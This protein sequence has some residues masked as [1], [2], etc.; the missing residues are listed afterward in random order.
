MNTYNDSW[1][2]EKA[3]TVSGEVNGRVANERKVCINDT[4]Y[5]LANDKTGA[6]MDHDS[7]LY[8]I[9]GTRSDLENGDDIMLVIVGDIAYYAESVSGNDANRSVA[10]VYD[11]YD[12]G[13]SWNDTHQ[14]KIILANGDKLTVDVDMDETNV[15]WAD[16]D[17][18]DNYGKLY[19]Y[20]VN[21]DDEYAFT[22]LS[23]N[24]ED[25]G[26][27]IV[28]DNNAG[29]DGSRVNTTA[30]TKYTI[31]DEAI[32][33]AYIEDKRDAEVYTGEALKD[34]NK[35]GNWGKT[36]VGQ[37]LADNQSGFTYARMLNIKIDDAD[38][39][40]NITNYGYMVEDSVRMTRDGVRVMRYTYWN[41]EE[42]VTSYEETNSNREPQI[43][44]GA[45][46][47]FSL[48]EDD[49]ITDVEY[50]NFDNT[51]TLNDINN[52][53]LELVYAAMSG[54]D[55]DGY[56]GI[57]DKDGDTDTF[58]FDGDTLAYYVNADAANSSDI[59]V[60]GSGLNYDLDADRDGRYPINI[61]YILDNDGDTIK[62]IVIDVDGDLLDG[63]KT[64]EAGQQPGG[65]ETDE[66]ET[67]PSTSEKAINI[68]APISGARYLDGN[69]HVQFNH[70]SIDGASLISGELMITDSN[71]ATRWVSFDELAVTE[72]TQVSKVLEIPY[73]TTADGALT[74]SVSGTLSVDEWYVEYV[75]G[76][77]RP[78][79]NSVISN[80][81]ETVANTAGAAISFTIEMPEGATE[82]KPNVD[83]TNV[84]KT[85]PVSNLDGSMAYTADVAFTGTL[86]A[87]N[88]Q[89]VVKIDSVAASEYAASISVGNVTDTA[90][91]VG[92]ATVTGNIT[93]L[94]AGAT[95]PGVDL[96]VNLTS[97]AA[98]G[99]KIV[100]TYTVN[101]ATKTLTHNA[102]A[103]AAQTVD[104][105]NSIDAVA[106]KTDIVIT[107]IEKQGTI[108]VG[109]VTGLN[110]VTGTNLTTPA[111]ATASIKVYNGST[112]LT[113]DALT[114]IA[115]GTELRVVVELTAGGP[116]LGDGVK[117]TLDGVDE[118]MEAGET[119][120]EFNYTM[121]N[122]ATITVT[123]SDGNA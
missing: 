115:A 74:V 13:N 109:S 101:G 81:T 62:F 120:V 59:G 56:I 27:D 21:N 52:N 48:G 12:Q 64:G 92:Y 43:K 37:V 71:G 95:D 14:A 82:F 40:N 54:Y 112:E 15:I 38:K 75:D 66:V 118:E 42:I 70:V 108:T 11:T 20:E 51:N 122:T 32:V 68:S 28:A 4:W 93:Q 119:Q 73:S 63:Q 34:A 79:A 67:L 2:V 7:D 85:A 106:G 53:G 99:D 9:P 31:A 78:L 49:L 91:G 87:A 80:A 5:T 44:K 58:E 61:A 117:F 50:A 22:E 100:V 88:T 123:A 17:N 116:V 10:M 45:I 86:T 30:G 111:S 121:G 23:D 6:D 94:A 3:E 25:A 33:F 76:S 114:D 60:E 77:N 102:T 55:A 24:G 41:G 83:L 84:T 46:I 105:A 35:T 8:T 57:V 18:E 113:G 26:Y 16:L 39:F 19:Y 97:A 65:D 72:G 98:V 96:T 69:L 89:P 110:T 104:L 90:N 103:S 107:N 1:I 29:V 36:D 47:G